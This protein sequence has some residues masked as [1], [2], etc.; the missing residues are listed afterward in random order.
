[1]ATN[2]SILAWTEHSMDRTTWR[3][4]VHKVTESDTTEWLSKQAC[5]QACVPLHRGYFT[6]MFL[7]S[8]FLK[9]ISIENIK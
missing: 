6:Y 1:M 2:S 4:T 9:Y 7:F 5:L 3:A 8:V